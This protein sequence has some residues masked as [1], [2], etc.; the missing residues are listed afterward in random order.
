LQIHVTDIKLFKP[1]TTALEIL[2]AI[3][4]TTRP[5]ELIFNNPPYEYEYNLIPFDILSG[6]AIMRET[7]INRQLLSSEKERWDVEIQ[8]FKKEFSDISVYP[9]SY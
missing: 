3:I 8:K 2:D 7:L 5:G 1:V 4:E 6:D 9:E